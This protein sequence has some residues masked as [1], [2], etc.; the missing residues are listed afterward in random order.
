MAA[1][2]G[3]KIWSQPVEGEG[4]ERKGEEEKEEAHNV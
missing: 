3:P 4:S 2:S 1:A